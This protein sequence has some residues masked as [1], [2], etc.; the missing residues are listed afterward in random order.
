MSKSFASIRDNRRRAATLSVEQEKLAIIRMQVADVCDAGGW[1]F[2][3]SYDDGHFHYVHWLDAVELLR[4][5]RASLAEPI[6]L[7]SYEP[8]G[9]L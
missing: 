3:F 5:H 9:H 4:G 1:C 7:T 8:G 6:T 2:V